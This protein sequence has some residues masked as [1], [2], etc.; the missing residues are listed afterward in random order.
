[1][2]RAIGYRASGAFLHLMGYLCTFWAWAFKRILAQRVLLQNSGVQR[3]T[4]LISKWRNM[5][6]R[7]SEIPRVL[8]SKLGRDLSLS[9]RRK[10][11]YG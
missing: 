1:M 5:H 4:L 8:K 10:K 3:I 2:P 6:F 9:T 7:C 11:S